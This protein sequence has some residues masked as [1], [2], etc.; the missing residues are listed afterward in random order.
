MTPTQRKAMEQAM[1]ALATLLDDARLVSNGTM[2]ASALTTYMTDAE[3]AITAL[4]AALAEQPAEQEPVA[5][6]QIRRIYDGATHAAAMA[7]FM[8]RMDAEQP[9]ADDMGVSGWLQEAEDR[10]KRRA[11]QP[12]ESL[13]YTAPQ[14]AKRVPL[15][16]EQK[17][18][19]HNETGAGHALICL[20]ESYI[21][22]SA[23]GTTGETK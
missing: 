12:L 6:D 11:T 8:T 18:R 5:D 19:I 22:E 2:A 20:V 23:H 13:L 15:T 4:R 9:D 3:D 10:V 21:I 1:E 16:D 14:P 7:V 17:Q